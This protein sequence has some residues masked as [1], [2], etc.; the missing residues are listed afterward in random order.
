MPTFSKAERICSKV[1]IDALVAE[2]RSFHFPPFRIIWKQQ[3][4][5]AVPVMVLISVPKRNFKRAVDRNFLKRRIREAYRL[6]KEGRTWD[7]PFQMTLIYTGKTLLDQEA[8]RK[9]VAG[10]LDKMK[11]EQSK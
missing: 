9:A 4:E 1:A 8:I 6:E 2:G 10:L 7:H 11:H 5:Q 3:A